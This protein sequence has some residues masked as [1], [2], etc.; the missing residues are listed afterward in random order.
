[1]EGIKNVPIPQIFSKS[2]EV[3]KEEDEVILIPQ[4]LQSAKLNSFVVY[5]NEA[6]VRDQDELLKSSV[7]VDKVKA[8][9]SLYSLT[10][11]VINAQKHLN[12][13]ELSHVQAHLK[14]S[15][16]NFKSEYGELNSQRNIKDL[17]NDPDFYLVRTLEKIKGKKV[18][19]LADIFSK[20]VIKQFNNSATPKTVEDAIIL[21]LNKFGAYNY[22]FMSLSLGITK[23]TLLNHLVDKEL[24]Y[25]NPN[26]EV[27]DYEP[28]D[29]YLSGNVYQKLRDA[30]KYNLPQNIEALK[31][32]QPLPMLPS[33]LSNAEDIK[34]KCLMELGIDWEELTDA[35]KDRVFSKKIEAKIGASWI[36][37]E[38]YESFC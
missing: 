18:V 29:K 14:N 38:I 19:G 27:N 7:S 5:N 1:L 2:E 32:A 17:G 15:Y 22:D 10:L 30:I 20:R 23:E 4:E 37:K 3:K 26:I 8:F 31:K 28:K 35:Q 25:F 34:F 16:D 9:K 13:E 21:S 6:Y 36:P 24:I 33:P 11:D 12:D